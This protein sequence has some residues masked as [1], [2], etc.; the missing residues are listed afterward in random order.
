[1]WLL[2]A[3]KVGFR[4]LIAEVSDSDS[5]LLRYL[6]DRGLYPRTTLELVEREPFG[7]NITLKIEDKLISI[8]STAAE[9]IWVALE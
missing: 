4:G 8:G 3:V 6:G 9:H 5:A 7:G 1:M 2:T